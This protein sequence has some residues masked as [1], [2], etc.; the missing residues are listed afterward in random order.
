MK[1][2]TNSSR[3]CQVPELR[4]EPEEGVCAIK[5]F[6]DGREVSHLYVHDLKVQVGGATVR[7]GGIGGVWTHE[8]YRRRGFARRV[9]EDALDY[10]REEGHDLSLLFGIPDFYHRF[11]YAS[12]LPECSLSLLEKDLPK[13]ISDFRKYAE[14]DRNAVL[15]IY[16]ENNRLR[17]GSVVRRPDTWRGFVRGTSW[18]VDPE[19]WVLKGGR[20]YLVFDATEEHTAVAEVGYSSPEAFPWLAAGVG[21][22]ARRHGH[23]EVKLEMPPD[24][25]F[26]IFLR[27]YG[28]RTLQ[29]FPRN[30][31][32]MARIV[33][34]EALFSKLSGELSRRLR[35][36]HMADWEGAISIRT[37]E[38]SVGIR[39]EGGGVEVGPTQPGAP[40]V[41]LPQARLIQL[42]FGYRAAW[43]V[44]SEEGVFL[45][46]E[47]LPVAEALFP[48][49]YPYMWWSDRF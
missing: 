35:T 22:R 36:S 8:E 9:L 32:G 6:S 15:D 29:V 10:M 34:L 20:G 14:G 31:G 39:A 43:D 47:F 1:E 30:G 19:V 23:G 2:G 33:N 4:R 40:E 18:Y 38:G 5:L 28:C 25:P 45:P 16:K 26:A 41:V 12:A 37:E 46:P 11:G 7:A 3:I 44:A 42:L 21:E 49:G 27:R 17:T 48:Q 13:D 24:H